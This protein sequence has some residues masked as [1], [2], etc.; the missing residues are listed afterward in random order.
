MRRS[1]VASVSTVIALGAICLPLLAGCSSTAK[2]PPK[3]VPVKTQQAELKASDLIASD[4]FGVSVAISGT[5]AVVGTSGTSYVGRAYVFTKSASRWAKVAE[6]KGSDTVAQDAFGSSVAI[7]GNT[8]VV[9]AFNHANY[10]GRA[11]VFS[12]TTSG[13][14]QVA[15]LKGSDTV[16]DDSFGWSVAVSGPTVFVG[17]VG[18]SKAAGRVYVF[19]DIAGDWSQTAELAASDAAAKSAFGT[20]VAVSGA[21]AVVG[22]EGVAKGA[23]AAYFF[24]DSDDGWQQVAEVKGS[25]TAAGDNFGTSVAISGTTAAI[26]GYGHADNAGSAYVFS[27]KSGI[28]TQVAE[29]KAAGLAAEDFSGIS[30]AVSSSTVLVGADG[31]AKNAGRVFEFTRTSSGWKEAAVLKGS[32]TV[33]GDSLGVSVA[34]SGTTA[35]VGADDRAQHAGRAYVF[36]VGAS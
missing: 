7:S 9:G 26:G 15:E 25:D 14:K 11:Y 3:L 21:N 24:A 2:S 30:T 27:R 28:W 20:S 32:D 4:T 35:V 36:S 10:A 19:T 23:G 13:W 8:I 16:A 12:K 5:T 33:A 6:L 34:L 1:R 17:A 31:H 18:H 29:L 22:A